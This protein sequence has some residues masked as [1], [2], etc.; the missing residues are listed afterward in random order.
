MSDHVSRGLAQWEPADWRRFL[1]D[2][3]AGLADLDE[4]D[5]RDRDRDPDLAAP[6]RDLWRPAV[7]VDPRPD[8]L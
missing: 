5:Q 1:G 6:Y 8:Y 3:A 2:D 7:T 4:R